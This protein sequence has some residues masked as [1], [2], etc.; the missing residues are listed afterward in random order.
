M[1][2]KIIAPIA[3]LFFLIFLGFLAVYIG[4][5]A[6]WVVMVIVGAMAAYDFLQQLR[7]GS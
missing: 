4:E 1:A 6:L 2:D 5:I 3:L 7:S